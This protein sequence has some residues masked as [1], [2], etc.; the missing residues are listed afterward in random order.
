MNAGRPFI[1]ILSPGPGALGSVCPGDG[2]CDSPPM[3]RSAWIHTPDPSRL[4]WRG[5]GKLLI[6]NQIYPKFTTRTSNDLF[7][8]LR[9]IPL[10]L[11]FSFRRLFPSPPTF[12]LFLLLPPLPSLSVLAQTPH[13]QPP[14]TPT[15]SKELLPSQNALSFD[16]TFPEKEGGE[17]GV[18][19]V[20]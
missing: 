18:E 20:V 8:F 3:Q 17:G 7:P 6:Q 2:V 12:L 15:T 11:S 14:S 16:L 5:Q 19:L 9:P 1:A 4:G 10:H 13:F